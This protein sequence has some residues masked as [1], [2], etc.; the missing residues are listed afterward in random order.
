MKNFVLF[1]LIS[2][3]ISNLCAKE[4]GNGGD[5]L[6]CGN[7]VRML[8]YAEADFYGEKI[9]LRLTTLEETVF[10]TIGRLKQAS[11]RLQKML[12]SNAKEILS[13]LKI[14]YAMA[15]APLI[16][17]NQKTS[18]ILFTNQDLVDIPDSNHLAI[19][20]D[21]NPKPVQI[22]I[23]KKPENQYQKK[24]LINHLL[25]DRLDLENTVALVLHESIYQVAWP[26]YENNP[27]NPHHKN[28]VQSRGLNL[29]LAANPDKTNSEIV[30]ALKD[31]KFY[32]PKECFIDYNY[33]G[34]F[35]SSGHSF[36]I[37]NGVM[38][39][40]LCNPV[41]Q[42][43][44][45]FSFTFTPGF[46]QL[47]TDDQRITKGKIKSTELTY[48]S[49]MIKLRDGTYIET[50][51]PDSFF[52]DLALVDTNYLSQKKLAQLRF[53]DNS[54][55]FKDVIDKDSLTFSFIDSPIGKL[56]GSISSN[57]GHLNEQL[58]TSIVMLDDFQSDRSN[59]RY[60]QYDIKP[61][62]FTFH[63]DQTIT[64]DA[65]FLDTNQVTLYLVGNKKI[66][67]F[68]EKNEP[69]FYLKLHFN[70]QKQLLSAIKI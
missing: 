10:N 15:G 17:I 42:N 27:L 6:I 47:N 59:Y 13:D 11:P 16:D 28:S 25:L 24:L 18:H 23:F 29:Y 58:T 54:F 69:I 7:R 3:A 26:Y 34:F 38:D 8:D 62:R 5:V 61:C 51:T 49:T 41:E 12:E 48:N 39:T 36:S 57:N 66:I 22:A 14:Y 40:F 21:C 52:A 1:L 19:P 45:N 20:A 43:S 67:F 32:S 31:F 55:S 53:Q 68:K 50:I 63:F 44:G 4:G 2:Q 64:M 65:E 9:R 46:I 60:Q 35:V 56:Q 70:H 33:H 30:E 37:S